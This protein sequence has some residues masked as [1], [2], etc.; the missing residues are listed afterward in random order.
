MKLY[1]THCSSIYNPLN[2]SMKFIVTFDGDTSEQQAQAERA[3]AHLDTLSTE[4]LVEESIAFFKWLILYPVTDC[5]QCYATV[6]LNYFHSRDMLL[7]KQSVINPQKQMKERYLVLFSMNGHV[8]TKTY[9]SI[10]EL[11][12]DTGKKPSQILCKP[13]NSLIC[14]SLKNNLQSNTN[15]K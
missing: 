4:S 7:N 1:V 2:E 3:I 15:R 13:T 8:F 14:K 9:N 10:R 11:K 6:L 12:A 5:H